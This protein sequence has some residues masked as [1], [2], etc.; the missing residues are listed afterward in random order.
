M[1]V[2]K[3]DGKIEKRLATMYKNNSGYSAKF[4]GSIF[5]QSLVIN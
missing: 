3:L 2:L 1:E 4:K 5:V